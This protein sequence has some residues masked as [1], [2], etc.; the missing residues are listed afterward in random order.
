[1]PTAVAV[2]AQT[3]Q[4]RFAGTIRD[5]TSAFV[6]GAKVKVKNER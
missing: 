3:D 6:G 2:S 4:G 1:V 5:Q